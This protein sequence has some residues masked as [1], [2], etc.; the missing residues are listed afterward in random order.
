MQRAAVSPPHKIKGTPQ[1]KKHHVSVADLTEKGLLAAIGQA[2]EVAHEIR[3]IKRPLIANAVRESENPAAAMNVI[4]VAS[5]MPGAGKTF[6]ALNLAVSISLERELNVLLVDADV[7]KPQIS[8]ELGLEDAPGLIDL[9]FDEEIDVAD[10]LVRTDLNDILV[11][12]A[13]RKH[14]Q[15]TELLASDRMSQ[16]VRELA[17]R[18][19]DRI[20]ILDSPPLLMTSEA[21]ALATHVGQIALV[22]EAGR[23]SHQMLAHALETLDQSKA[24]NLILNKTRRSAIGGQYGEYGY[25]D[26]EPR[27]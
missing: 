15:A 26:Q 18:Y 2:T 19:R 11:L 22:V 12:P 3:K 5:A 25:Y 27:S 23:T 6:C 7:P 21:Q 17:T 8:R 10:L 14:P 9:L 4:M 13:G 1:G 24:I 16:I 20:V